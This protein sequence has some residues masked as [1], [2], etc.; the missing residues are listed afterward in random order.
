MS[1][2]ILNA[3]YFSLNIK[4]VIN[5]KLLK[6]LHIFKVICLSPKF[7]NYFFHLFIIFYKLP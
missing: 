5:D 1:R 2:V 7:H 3:Q 4:N 6:K